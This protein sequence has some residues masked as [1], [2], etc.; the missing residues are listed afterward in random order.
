MALSAPRREWVRI[1]HASIKGEKIL[2][3]AIDPTSDTVTQAGALKAAVR[4][5]RGELNG[6]LDEIE[7]SLELNADGV[8]RCIHCRNDINTGNGY[9]PSGDRPH[10]FIRGEVRLKEPA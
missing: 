2:T 8:T 4:Y 10:S 1:P 3:P 6:K 5:V 7:T 9:C